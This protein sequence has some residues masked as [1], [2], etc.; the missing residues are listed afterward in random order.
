[1]LTADWLYCTVLGGTER[2]I[3]TKLKLYWQVSRTDGCSADECVCESLF[4]DLPT[5]VFTSLSIRAV[6]QLLA[7]KLGLLKS[8]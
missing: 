7:A 3:S 2:H 5:G 4:E 8:L 6:Q 1:M